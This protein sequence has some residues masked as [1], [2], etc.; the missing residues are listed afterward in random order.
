MKDNIVSVVI[1][2]YNAGLFLEKCLD[3]IC[4][5]TYSNLEIICVD[6][7]STDDSPKIL[8]QYAKEDSR[9]VVI[10]TEGQSRGAGRAR[11]AGLKKATGNYVVF[12]DADDFFEPFLIE[13]ALEK[14][15]K[16]NADMVAYD[17]FEYNNNTGVITRPSYAIRSQYLP[18]QEVFSAEDVSHHLFQLFSGSVWKFL[19][20]REFIEKNG[21]FFQEDVVL[22]DDLFF[23]Y[24]ALVHAGRITVLRDRLLYYRK[25]V[26]NSQVSCRSSNL[27]SVYE[28]YQAIVDRLKQ[29]NHYDRVRTSLL[30][31]YLTVQYWIMDAIG[32]WNTY[33]EE[34]R[35]VRE[36]YFPSLGLDRMK[37]EEIEDSFLAG[38]RT[39]ILQQE[40]EQLLV[41]QWEKQRGDSLFLEISH[42]PLQNV[43]QLRGKKVVLYG[44]GRMGKSYFVQLIYGNAGKLVLWADKNA[45]SIGYPVSD[46][47]QIYATEFDIVLIALLDRRLIEEVSEELIRHG[48][49]RNQ[50]LW[51]GKME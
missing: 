32:D 51:A 4:S 11:N 21:L 13:R 5:Q 17:I 1:P 2:V 10:R 39:Q 35:K 26:V 31:A 16:N 6:D 37:E 24:T 25:Q 46:T 41:S 45:A 23:T 29:E 28:A 18:E 38:W 34:Y 42:Y 7:Q 44:A 22:V 40:A 14:A 8:Q 50:I 49:Q 48:V 43:E 36:I 33:A 3:S 9:M 47:E 12:L 19:I 27:S 15:E 30:N 20:K